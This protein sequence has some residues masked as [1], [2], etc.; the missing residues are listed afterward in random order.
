MGEGA[1]G[2]HGLR[3]GSASAFV[4]AMRRLMIRATAKSKNVGL[5]R[6]AVAAFLIAFALAGPTLAATT[7]ENRL[8]AR[9]AATAL[10]KGN[11]GLAV[12]LYTQALADP[13]I[14]NDRR[15]TLLND[16][17]VA[18]VRLGRTREALKDYN[19]AVEL[20]PENAAAYNN[21][22]NLLMALGFDDEA[23]KDFNRAVALAPGYAAAY[24]NRAGALMRLGKTSQAVEDFTRAV[25]LLPSNAAPL[26]GRG[27][28]HLAEGRPHAAIRDFTRAVTTNTRFAEGYRS[29]A[30]AKLAVEQYNEAIEDLSRA[31]AFDAKVPDHYLLRGHAYLVLG[32]PKAAVADFTRVTE[33]APKS[34]S[35]HEARG[36]GATFAEDFDGALADLNNAISLN[37][38]SATAFAYRAFAYAQS[39]QLGLAKQD[40]VTA[41]KLDERNAEVHWAAAEIDAVSGKPDEAVRKL[42]LALKYKPGFK[43]A[44]ETLARLGFKPALDRDVLVEGAGKLGWKVV[45]RNARFYAINSRLKGLRVPLELMGKGQ[46]KIVSWE[47]REA[48]YAQFGVLIFSAGVGTGLNDEPIPFEQ[49]A[50][51]DKDKGVVLAIQPHRAG[52]KVS[53]WTWGDDGRVRVAS[54]D[55]FVDE[56]PIAVGVVAAAAARLRAR[57][58]QRRRR[59]AANRA[60]DWAPWAE[61][62]WAQPQQR[63]RRSK[64]RRKKPKSFFQLLFNN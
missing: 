28:A 64:R 52:K 46:P 24:N 21:R 31:I 3:F 4:S 45:T 53:Q 33:L 5:V 1:R 61:E 20:F 59:A 56:L 43:R 29:R 38:R 16:R 40:V 35:G 22:G 14:S 7:P 51:I 10:I 11:A 48:P 47:E 8:K 55:G 17:A 26:S 39:G 15:A 37:P 44:R 58:R 30:E 57:E 62:S 18:Y 27:R 12:E 32:D 41:R 13:S 36:L 2:P 54:V 34:A 6:T 9:D 50:I 60:P 19:Q 49:A 42:R 25:R 23:L 63:K